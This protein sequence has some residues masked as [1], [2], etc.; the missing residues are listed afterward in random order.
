ML[1]WCPHL[2]SRS[3]HYLRGA[4]KVTLSTAH[5]WQQQQSL[6]VQCASSRYC[7][8]STSCQ[9]LLLFQIRTFVFVL[10]PW[11]A[12][13]EAQAWLGGLGL[14]VGSPH[15]SEASSH[16]KVSQSDSGNA[17]CFFHTSPKKYGIE[18]CIMFGRIITEWEMLNHIID[19]AEVSKPFNRPLY[20]NWR[21][22]FLTAT[23]WA[24]I[25]T[26]SRREL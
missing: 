16:A 17:H 22:F 2:G 25:W 13:S 26:F 21:L 10:R 3:C 7:T 6:K 1:T 8:K 11:I 14:R 23:F 15:C 20:T 18:I 4:L 24:N 5:I 12:D 9:K 19:R